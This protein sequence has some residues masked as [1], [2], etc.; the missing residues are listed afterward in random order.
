MNRLRDRGLIP[1]PLLFWSGIVVCSAGVAEHIR[2]F[3]DAAEMH[4]HMAHMTMGASMWLAMA[5]I[6]FGLVLSGVGLL[7]RRLGHPPTGAPGAAG[8]PIPDPPVSA[9]QRTRLRRRLVAVLSFALVVDQMK[10]ATLAFVLPGARAEYGLT[11]AEVAALPMGGLTGTVLGSLLWGH[12]ADRIGRRS[13]V[14]LAALLFVATTVCGAMPSFEANVL[15]CLLM[16][17]SAGGMLPIVY[18][19]MSEVFPGR[20]GLMVLT[21]GLT[22][23]GGYLAVSGLSALLEPSYGWRSL[24][25]FQLPLA[26]ALL[27]L[28]RWIPESPSF[29]ESRGRSAEARRMA[30]Q[31]GLT[32]A[33]AEPRTPGGARAL[34]GPGYLG[35]TLVISGFALSWG[36]V[37]WGFVTFL[38]TVLKDS[39]LRTP[40][41]EI[42]FASALLSV[43]GTAV[44]AWLYSRWSTRKTMTLYGAI[45][46]G[47]LIA[48]IAVP[49][50][51]PR[52]AVPVLIGLLTGASGVVSVLG[53]YTAQVYPTAFRGLGSGLSAACSKSGGIVGPPLVGWMLA[54][55]PLGR[56]AAVIAVPMALASGAIA[57]YGKET[58]STAADTGRTPQAPD[59]ARVG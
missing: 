32:R 26:L 5:A 20:S 1:R 59:R 38:P 25:F 6:V 35:Q 40:A 50:D 12:L 4:Y 16:G 43:P 3:V 33:P 7:P 41:S 51:N 29:L 36:L 55:M 10:P 24:W 23:V 8:S 53:P 46:A 11:A 34:L 58:G 37:Y 18:A 42:L 47:S 56:V 52:V 45:T 2:M 49:L 17:M 28:N 30:L 21:A 54:A 27:G 44:A 48:L 22:T 9:Q 57:R 14:L 31:F 39:G 15:M 19:L 13:S